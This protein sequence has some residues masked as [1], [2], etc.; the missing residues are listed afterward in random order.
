MSENR[1]HIFFAHDILSLRDTKLSE[2]RRYWGQLMGIC[3]MLCSVR[4]RVSIMPVTLGGSVIVPFEIVG[5]IPHFD[6]YRTENFDLCA[7]RQRLVK[8]GSHSGRFMDCARESS[9]TCTRKTR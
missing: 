4:R 9:V 2:T 6:L 5:F 7:T 1:W 3:A 8:I